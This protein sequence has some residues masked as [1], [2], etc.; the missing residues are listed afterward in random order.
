MSENQYPQQLEY[1]N[2][3]PHQGQPGYLGN[4]PAYNSG[5]SSPDSL[6]GYP[7]EQQMPAYNA[8][9]APQYT[10]PSAPSPTPGS[11]LAITALVFGIAGIP[12]SLIP[13]LGFPLGIVGVVLGV[14]V[15]AK[16]RSNKASGRGMAI[17]G[18]VTGGIAIMLAILIFLYAIVSYI[19]LQNDCGKEGIPNGSGQVVCQLKDGDTMTVRAR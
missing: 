8:P 14:V 7:A 4:Q 2:R 6:N 9:A 13:L 16:A 5:Y 17:A 18:I 19:N 15:L 3:P 1:P 12:L 11:G 10:Y